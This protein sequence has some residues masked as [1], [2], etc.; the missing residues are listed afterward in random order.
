MSFIDCIRSA[1]ESGRVKSNKGEEAIAAFEEQ[2][3]A[4]LAEGLSEQAARDAASMRAVESMGAKTQARKWEKI[5]EVRAQHKLYT[6]LQETKDVPEFYVTIGDMAEI[7]QT[8]IR[9]LTWARMDEFVEQSRPRAAGTIIPTKHLPDVVRAAYGR[10]TKNPTD[11]EMANSIKDMIDFTRKLANRQG[12]SIPENKRTFLPQAHSTVKVRRIKETIEESKAE[13]IKDQLEWLDWDNMEYH[14]ERIAPQN[15]EEVLSRVYDTIASGGDVNIRPGIPS[16]RLTERMARQRF[17]HY[18]DAD[19]WLANNEKYGEGDLFQQVVGYVESM[20]REIGLMEVFGPNPGTSLN[21]MHRT[22]M[23]HAAALDLAPGTRGRSKTQGAKVDAAISRFNERYKL[24]SRNLPNSD[25]SLL[26]N[27][28]GTA[29]TAV[30]A[31]LLSGAYI[32]NLSDLSIMKHTAMLN[33]LPGVGSVRTYLKFFKSTGASREM[34]IRAGMGADGFINVAQA[35]QR[36]F[37]PL[38]GGVWAKRYSDII[39]RAQLLNAHNTA[40]K[41]AWNY[42]MQGMFANLS[43][44]RYDDLPMVD[45]FRARGITEEDWNLFRSQTPYDPE[46]MNLLRPI[47][48]FNKPEGTPRQNMRVGE[49]F[50][51]YIL[52]TRR[53]AV[54]EGDTRTHAILGHTSDP[55]T[56]KGQFVRSASMFVTFPTTMLI[57]HGSRGIRQVGPGI[58]TAYLASLMLML[59]TAGAFVTQVRELIQGRDPLPMV[60]EGSG[61]FWLRSVLNGGSMG[62]LGDAILGSGDLRHQ[63]AGALVEF[64]NDFKNLSKAGITAVEQALRGERVDSG[65][66]KQTLDFLGRY[67]PWIWYMRLIVNRAIFDQ[68]QKEADP[69]AWRRRQQAER[70]RAIDANQQSWWKSGEL[71]PSRAPDWG[72][73]FGGARR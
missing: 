51:D 43:N 16:E 71:R 10:P 40:A 3:Q 53:F 17:L 22:A 5:N 67:G 59:T 2:Y 11:M 44:T 8:R 66:S 39:M 68:L 24:L 64:A 20:S 45:Q 21:F 63:V 54:P 34:A 62:I 73:V 57:R 56:W 61:R 55:R 15:R 6:M 60:G 26:A 19:S 30:G 65:L 41:W 58:K 14:G 31:S 23:Q 12:A 32:M 35:Q 7:A 9:D 25:E 33:N 18:K 27:I 36:A 13:W 29:R 46:G 48:L 37:G 52:D 50:M 47:D 28:G 72:A 42:D 1:I 49:K 70:R 69:A 38:M 4:G